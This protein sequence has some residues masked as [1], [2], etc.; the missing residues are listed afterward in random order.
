[1]FWWILFGLAGV[2]TLRSLVHVGPAASEDPYQQL[3]TDSNGKLWNIYSTQT[4]DGF[5]VEAR[6]E[7]YWHPGRVGFLIVYGKDLAELERMIE[8]NAARERNLPT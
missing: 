7:A 2:W 1:M 5:R 4:A 8:T 6:T 3:Y